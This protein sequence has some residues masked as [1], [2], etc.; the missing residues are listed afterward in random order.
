MVSLYCDSPV[1]I[2][3]PQLKQLVLRY[4]TY[5][6]G[7]GNIVTL[8]H[9]N[10]S[11]YSF[12][13]PFRK[14]SKYQT[15][16][17]LLTIDDYYILDILTSATYPIYITVPCG[18][19]PLCRNKKSAEWSFRAVCENKTS[20]AVPL[21]VT[22]TYNADNLPSNGIS[23]V[24]V[25]LFLKRLRINLDRLG[26]EHS[27]RY[28]ACG[29][30]G[31]KS[32]RPHYHLIIWSFPDMR[33]LKERLSVIEKSWQQGFCYV[34]PCTHGAIS[35][36]MKYMKKTPIVPNGCEPN[37]FLSSRKGGGI[38]A[39]YAKSLMS[40]FRENPTQLE[41]SVTDPYSGKTFTSLLPSYFK[42][43][44][45][46][47][48]SKLV[49]KQVSDDYKSLQYR[50]SLRQTY[51]SLMPNMPDL[52]IVHGHE[53][54]I[55]KRFNFLSCYIKKHTDY[56]L[57]KTLSKSSFE[58][59]K[60]LYFDNESF[61]DSLV[62]SLDSVSFD[63]DYIADREAIINARKCALTD[64]FINKPLIDIESVKITLKNRESLSI[65]RE[66][67]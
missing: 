12:D 6:L 45:F 49:T 20:T 40:Y 7:D 44:Y 50:L 59:I 23:K 13:F 42:N 62:E 67:I 43:L 14:F 3:N 17:T 22:L 36:V 57:K 25:Q 34:V 39:A 28:F 41:I 27:L 66:I 9:I 21:F 47:P 48:N 11:T 65:S 24:A 51:R 38:G 18:K 31:T 35:Y 46:P 32:K 52:P 26:I 60:Y 55:I 54:D 19:C 33:T 10:R 37:F 16:V 8:T 15:G 5:C 2:L 4:G 64:R 53:I 56:E 30:Y 29:E 58:H 61:I 63:R 1:I